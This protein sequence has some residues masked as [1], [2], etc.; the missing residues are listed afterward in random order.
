MEKM[1]RD[2]VRCHKLFQ[3]G[4]MNKSLRGQMTRRYC[5]MCKILQHR[6]ES[7]AYS[8]KYGRTNRKSQYMK[9]YYQKNK[10]YFLNKQLKYGR[11]NR[12]ELNRKARIKYRSELQKL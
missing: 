8:L 10:E 11:D 9:E 3:Y 1:T 2:C 12:E 5:Y 7:R 6:D 4:D